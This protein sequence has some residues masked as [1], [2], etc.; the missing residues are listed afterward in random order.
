[1]NDR[2]RGAIRRRTPPRAE[3]SPDSQWFWDHYEVAP[4][5]IVS[6]CESC[7]LSLKERAIAD[8]GSG[9]G[10]MAMGLCRLVLPRKLAGFDIVPTNAELLLG[11]ARA[12]GVAD[13]LLPAQLE[14]R[15]S[16]A[17]G[18][19]AQD[20]EFDFVYSWSAFEHIEKPVEVL[21]EI[22]RALSPD[23]HFFLQL[24]PFYRSAKGSHLWDWFGDFHHLGIPDDEIV[25]QLNASDRHSQDW[26][27]YMAG[28]FQHLNRITIDQLQRAV[29]AAGFDVRRIELV[30]A[31]VDLTPELARYSWA[32]LAIGGIKLLATPRP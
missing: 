18:L 13:D 2:I 17:V 12:E 16:T 6:F 22:R 11:R 30:S 32:D 3:P 21:R 9:D 8:I 20:G 14:F 4:R 15:H 23:G 31:P 5:E 1:M 19:P 10:I 27:A 25:A 7:G 28:E 24:W 29:L 26:T